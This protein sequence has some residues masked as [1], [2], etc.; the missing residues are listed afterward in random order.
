MHIYL[1][2]GDYTACAILYPD[3]FHLILRSKIF[4]EALTIFKNYF[5]GYVIIYCMI[6]HTLIIP[7]LWDIGFLRFFTVRITL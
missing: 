3:F 5:R 2:N 7:L 4:Y 1:H 6:W